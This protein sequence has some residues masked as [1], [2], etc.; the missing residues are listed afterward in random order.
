M[1][2]DIGL[3]KYLTN[4]SSFNKHRNKR[5]SGSDKENE[6]SILTA[7]GYIWSALRVN[8]GLYVVDF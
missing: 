6:R 3:H 5:V 2:N 8:M 1:F 4:Y 7:L